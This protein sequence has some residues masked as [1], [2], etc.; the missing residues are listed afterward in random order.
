[1]TIIWTF[2]KRLLLLTEAPVMKIVMQTFS[3]IS[4]GLDMLTA[5]ATC[6]CLRVGITPVNCLGAYYNTLNYLYVLKVV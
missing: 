1:M 4:G 2:M 5:S 6:C 3:S